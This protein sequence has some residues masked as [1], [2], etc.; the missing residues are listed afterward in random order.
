M[1]VKT[2]IIG[3]GIMGRRML[4]HMV[5]HDD[6]SPVTLWDPDPRACATAKAM[7]PDAVLTQSAEAAMDSADLV[8][9]ACPPGPRRAYALAAAAAGKAVFLEKPLGVDLDA[10]ED[11]V[12]RLEASGVPAAVNFVQASGDALAGVSAAAE[13]GAMGDLV[14]AEIILTYGAW[15]RAWQQAADWLRYRDEGGMIREVVSHFLFFTERLLG[16]LSVEWARPSFPSDPTLCE[17][18]MAARLV[19]E[20]GRPVSVLASVG[21]ALPDRQELTIK[22][23]RTS[24]RITDFY[25]DAVSDGG[26]FTEIRPRPKD[27][28]ATSLKAQL[29]G[30]KL[31]I[32]GQ[33]HR[34]ASPR[35]ALRVQQLVEAM[36]R[37][38]G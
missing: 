22:G 6:F 12:A 25:I 10:S 3:L 2:A 8:Y 15:P 21:G 30:L 31:C 27:P 19:T 35:E 16:P 29:D 17:T 11:L 34:L 24:R 38:M 28:R 23:T 36:L 1:T 7:A 9:L 4:E 37:G 33:P 14:G 26:A 5:R 18:Q 32:A 13:S 20:D